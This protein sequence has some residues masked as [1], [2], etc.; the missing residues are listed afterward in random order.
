MKALIPGYEIFPGEHCGS[1][2]MRGLLKH[3]CGLSLPEPAVFGLSAGLECAYL[4]SPAMDPSVAVFGRTATL[5]TDLGRILGIDYREQRDPDDDHAWQAVREE[6]LG[7]QPTM[8]SGDILYLDYREFKVHFPGHRFV[9][10][11]F[12][13]EAQQVFIADRIRPE[14][15][16]CSYAALRKS[17]NPPE[18][19]STQN[20]WG[21]F[22]G[23]EVGRSLR[24][25][26]RLA[27]R[28]CAERMLGKRREGSAG[29]AEGAASE[30]ALGV[31]GIRRFAEALPGWAL[32]QDARWVAS[33]NARTIEKFGNG[34]GNFRRL[35]AGFLAWAR[36]LDPALAPAGAPALATRAADGWTAISERLAAASAEGAPEN[37]FDEAAALARELADVEQALFEAL[38]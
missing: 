9:L 17:R 2:S 35:Y 8:L 7:G 4:E 30:V 5:E 22:H 18:G 15:E 26:A 24:D 25:A 16:V 36:E 3:Y 32:R 10:L 38:A 6:V 27:I 13:D 20:L 34:G 12:D 37:L 14:P 11:G 33:F 1:A 23:R 29:F 28:E 19:L 31:A 21:R